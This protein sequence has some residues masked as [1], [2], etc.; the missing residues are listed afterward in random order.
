MEFPPALPAPPPP[1]PDQF[2]SAFPRVP[3]PPLFPCD[4]DNAGTF[5]RPAAPLQQPP[6]PDP[7]LPPLLVCPPNP[8]PAAVVP[9]KDDAVP[10]FPLAPLEL[11]T[12]SPPFPTEIERVA[13]TVKETPV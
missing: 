1:P 10:E 8:P 12:A 6:P 7:P 2:A 5:P 9:L 4:G 3:V 13:P 11:D